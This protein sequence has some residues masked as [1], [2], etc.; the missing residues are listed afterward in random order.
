VPVSGGERAALAA[1][2]TLG[3]WS[4]R[5]A[6]GDP[7]GATALAVITPGD[8]ALRG[9]AQ[10]TLAGYRRRLPV[11]AEPALSL[12]LAR[13]HA[14]ALRADR[15]GMPARLSAVQIAAYHHRVF[16]DFGLPPTGFAATPLTGRPAEARLS[17]WLWCRGCDPL[18]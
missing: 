3:F 5:A 8:G 15:Q 12:A 13:A 16:G 7:F 10:A 9:V 14:A 6:R 11:A 2:D 18:P 17:A 4:L 1:G